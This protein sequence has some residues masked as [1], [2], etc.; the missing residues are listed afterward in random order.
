MTKVTGKILEIGEVKKVSEKFQKLEFVIETQEQYPQVYAIQLVQDK[1]DVIKFYNV[2]SIVDVNVNIKGRAWQ[3]PNT[4]ETKYFVTLEAWS[5][6]LKDS[7]P[8]SSKLGNIE[9]SF[10]EDAIRQM[11]EDQDEPLAF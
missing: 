4:L 10:Q 6:S 5:I 1:V 3:N 8:G 2:G 7:A 9:E 11:E